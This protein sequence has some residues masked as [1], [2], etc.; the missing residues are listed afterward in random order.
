MAWGYFW[1]T[2]GTSF[3]TNHEGLRSQAQQVFDRDWA[4]D[5]AKPLPT[6]S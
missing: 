4:S 1:N 2:A 5:L 3:N 6:P